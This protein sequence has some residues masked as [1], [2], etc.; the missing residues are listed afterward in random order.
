M[1][2]LFAGSGPIDPGADI[3]VGLGARAGAGT[4]EILQLIDEC[5]NV[6]GSSR[7]AI[8][9]CVTVSA[10]RDHAG[11]RGA[12]AALGV[13]LLALDGDQLHEAVPNP[14]AKVIALTGLASIAEAAALHF[15]PLLVEKRRS[16]QA[17][18]ALSRAYG[19]MAASTASTLVTS[20][21]GA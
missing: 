6:A 1:S 15:G 11:M 16:T 8:A 12:A 17:T 9:A 5:L 2:E 18:C 3:V 7:S 21:A 13:P 10:R 20:F 4:T 19:A 14:S